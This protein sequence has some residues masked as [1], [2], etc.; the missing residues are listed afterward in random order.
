MSRPL[1]PW[2]DPNL[3]PFP[4]TLLCSLDGFWNAPKR[5]Q[6][7]RASLLPSIREYQERVALTLNSRGHLGNTHMTRQ[8]P[9][10]RVISACSLG[11]TICIAGHCNCRRCWGFSLWYGM[12]KAKLRL[13]GEAWGWGAGRQQGAGVL[14][15]QRA[16]WGGRGRLTGGE[17]HLQPERGRAEAGTSDVPS[18]SGRTGGGPRGGLSA[19]RAVAKVLGDGR[20]VQARG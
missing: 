3:N 18:K 6:A 15:C 7:H 20:A 13:R 11:Q 19:S 4:S 16:G 9:P 5:S 2:P 8:Q 14:L 12:S 10:R 17:V 1:G